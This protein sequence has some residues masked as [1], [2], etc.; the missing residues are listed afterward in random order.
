MWKN[1]GSARRNRPNCCEALAQLTEPVAAADF[2]RQHS[3][4]NQ[5]LRAVVKRG[6]A[7]LEEQA[8]QRDPHADETFIASSNLVLNEEQTAALRMVETAMA[9]TDSAK[10]MLLH[11]VTGSGKTEIYLQAIAL[12]GTRQGRDRARAGDLADAPDGRAIQG[13]FAGAKTTLRCCTGICP[14]ANG[15]MNGTRFGTAARGL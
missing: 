5:T 8:V 12:A 1:C 9:D 14:T 2:L 3:L 6:F 4:D 7:V 13:R 10:P 15:M 11:G